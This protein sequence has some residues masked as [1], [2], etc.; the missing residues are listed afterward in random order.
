MDR[1]TIDIITLGCSKNLVDSERLM[2]QL[3]AIGYHC[4]HDTDNPHGQIAII[5]TCGFIGDAK[6]E[7]INTILQFIERKNKHQ[8]SKLYVM[9]CLAERYLAD[10]ENELPEVD[11]FF[12]KFDFMNLL[13]QIK[14]LN[15]P[16]QVPSYERKVTTPRHYAYLKIAEGCNRFC[17]Y[18]AIPL[19]TG[20]YQSRTIEDIEAEVNWLAKQGVK[21]LQVIAQDLTYY[22][23]DIY[24]KPKIAELI[25]RISQIKGIEWIRLHYAYP[26]NFPLDLLKVMAQRDNVC[27]YLDIALQHSTDHMLSVMRRHITQQQQTQLIDTIRKEVPGIHIRTTLLVGHPGETA[28]DFE[29]LKQW[30]KKMRFERMGCFAYSNEEGTFAAQN[31]TDNIP[32]D[33]KTQRVEELMSIQEQIAD[34]INHS[35]VGKQM[36]IIIDRTEGNYY[37]GR[38]EFDSPEVDGE[39]LIDKNDGEL[40]IGKFYNALITNADTFDL[41][42]KII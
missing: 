23:I 24:H 2:R 35:K 15:E 13:S 12:G 30:T 11:G 1:K 5:N 31:Y 3:E 10:L 38:T 17:S 41:Y 27:K 34:E 28:E 4:T 32:Q 7:S 37:I 40:I 6:E 22:G 14:K 16:V 21:E 26:T 20:R 36:K 18:C 19:I 33:I 42:A 39:V 9:G 29:E 8:L 25:D